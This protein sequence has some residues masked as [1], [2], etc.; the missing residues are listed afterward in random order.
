[1][2]SPTPRP[3]TGRGFTLVELLVVIAIIGILVALLLPAVQAAREAARRSSCQSNLR[4]VGL[5]VMNFESARGRLPIG[6]VQRFDVSQDPTLYSWVS[7]VLQY[8]EEAAAYG[9]ADWT[10]PLADRDRA[11]NEAHH[12]EF[13]TLKCPSLEPV[14]LVNDFYGARGSYAVN[15]GIGQ[16][17]MHNPD[18]D[19]KVAGISGAQKWPFAPYAS[20]T[21]SLGASGVFLVNH[22][23]RLAEITDGTSKTAMVAEII[24]VVGEDT[25]GALHY[26]GAVMYM[27]NV[28][29]NDVS[30]FPDR[31]RYCVSIPENAPC[32]L[33]IN[34]WKGGWQ[35]A[36]RSQHPGG[37]HV[38]LADCSAQFIS[39]GIQLVNWQVLATPDGEEIATESF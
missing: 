30:S 7:Q 1:M 23:R 18:P 35:Q 5:A 20:A 3:A 33:T 2:V 36:A 11:G 17:Y 27:H 37:A 6:A 28:V 19:Q 13:A 26:G 10:I 24:N 8:I 32:Q 34:A 22:G 31:T 29:P 15:A 38:L 21:S 16:I 39:D 25:R 14:G 12:I 9:Q 4:Q